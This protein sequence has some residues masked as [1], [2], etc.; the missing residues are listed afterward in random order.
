MPGRK[1]RLKAIVLIEQNFA[2]QDLHLNPCFPIQEKVV[3]AKGKAAALLLALN[4]FVSCD[5]LVGRR[6]HRLTSCPRQPA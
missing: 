5:V 2:E 6:S 3:V 1:T 4:C